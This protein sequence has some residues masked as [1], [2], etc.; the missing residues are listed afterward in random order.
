[1]VAIIGIMAA[2]AGPAWVYGTGRAKANNAASELSSLASVAQMR[3]SS[4]GRPVYLIV[5]ETAASKG[6]YVVERDDP[7]PNWNAV[8]PANP[9]SIGGTLL[10]SRKLESAVAFAPLASVPLP[11]VAGRLPAPFAALPVTAVGGP[12]LLGACSFCI[13]AGVGGALGVLRYAADGT[14]SVATDATLAGGLVTLGI[15][16][17]P[18]AQNPKALA[19]STPGGVVRIYQ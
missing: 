5:W 17:S 4:S 18:E 12:G 8:D 19:I 7:A 13:A 1:V 6:F 2:L 16:H 14:V 9:A 11:L 10:E 15:N 3:A